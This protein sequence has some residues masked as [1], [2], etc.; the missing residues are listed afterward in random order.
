MLTPLPEIYSNQY[1]LGVTTSVNWNESHLIKSAFTVRHLD[2]PLV[3][4]VDTKLEMVIDLYY[5]LDATKFVKCVGG[6][7]KTMVFIATGIFRRQ[8]KRLLMCSIY[9]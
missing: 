3:I 4:L 5:H 7:N 9:P 1:L 6:K 8:G 2:L